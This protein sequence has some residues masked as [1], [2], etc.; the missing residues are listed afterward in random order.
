MEQ[1]STVETNA[2]RRKQIRGRINYVEM[3]VIYIILG[4]LTVIY[5]LPFL[6]LISSAFKAPTEI[7][8]NPIIWIPKILKWDNFY[9]ATHDIPF[10]LYLRNTLIIV[11]GCLVGSLISNSIVAY[12]F[13]KLKWKGRNALFIVV[14]IT[15]MIPFQIIMIPQFLFFHKIG[16]I[17]TFLPLIVP[18]FFGNAFFIFLLR[19]FFIGIPNEISQAAKVDGANEFV[20]FSRIVLPL[21]T[22]GLATVGIF[23]FLNTWNDFVGPLIFLSSD[24][25]YTLALGIQQIM[26]V[27]DPR[28]NI[29]MAAG[30]LMT[31][32]VLV[33]FFLLQRYFIQGIAFSGIKG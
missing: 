28:W 19:Q 15:M 31:V 10:F 16:W 23:T 27:N 30:V 18:A 33:L 26:S 21:S 5:V 14:L 2:T 11:A 1:Q 32:P 29:L 24:K 9:R 3:T 6:W 20:I 12:G 8:T 7:F 13:A 4:V 22:A 25:K 17:G